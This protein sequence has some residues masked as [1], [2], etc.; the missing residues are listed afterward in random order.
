M[1]ANLDVRG[2]CEF[3]EQYVVVAED[4]AFVEVKLLDWKPQLQLPPG[5]F[6]KRGPSA[7]LPDPYSEL[8][9]LFIFGTLQLS[10]STSS[11][12]M[13]EDMKNRLKSPN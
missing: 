11:E 1:C 6:T 8:V 9:R 3:K 13:P 10:G 4:S 7:A 5:Q 2:C 12:G